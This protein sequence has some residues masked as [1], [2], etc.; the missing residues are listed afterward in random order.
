MYALSFQLLRL[1]SLR[2]EVLPVLVWQRCGITEGRLGLLLLY[3]LGR[4]KG[5]YAKNSLTAGLLEEIE[6]RDLP[7]AKQE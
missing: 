2:C 6:P 1:C 5:N 3:S 4:V 7:D